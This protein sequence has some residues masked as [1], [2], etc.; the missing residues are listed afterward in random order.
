VRH[1]RSKIHVITTLRKPSAELGKKSFH[2]RRA[3]TGSETN[4]VS[5][6]SVDTGLD[7]VA[8]A[9]KWLEAE[10]AGRPI[11][12]LVIVVG[13]G[14]GYLLEAL[15]NR[16]AETRVLALEPDSTI[17]QAFLARRDWTR[18]REA[19][20]LAYLVDPDY[21]GADE[22]WRMFPAQPD[23]H[24]VLIDPAI[25]RDGGEGALR[26]ARLL[27]RIVFG[28]RANAEARRQFAPRYLTNAIRNVPSLI[29]GSDIRA[30]TDV[31]RG[32]P[33][34]IAAAGPSLDRAL[35][36]LRHVSDRAMLIA[37]DTALRP[38]LDYGLTPALAI[39]MDPSA[40]NGRHFHSLP[41]C[42]ETWL[43]AE[44]ALDPTAAALFGDR[45]F[46][47]RV[48][49]HQPWPWFH[50]LGIDVGQL[51]V[52]GS[53]LTAAFQVAVLAGC[54]PI[55][56][57]GADL[58]Y[59]DGRPYARG[60]TYEFDW[61]YSTGFGDDLEHV[62]RMQMAMLDQLRVPDLCGA[63]TTTTPP[64]EAF[65]DWMVAQAARCGRR[66]VNATGA[67]ILFGKGVEQ[68]SLRT[69]L[70]TRRKISS[71][72]D[73]VR[74]EPAAASRSKLATQF[75][76]VR[77]RIGEPSLAPVADWVEF[78]G[79]GFEAVVTGDA[80]E[81]AARALAT[82]EDGM[83]RHADNATSSRGACLQ[84]SGPILR[85][86]PEG[87]ARL[88][89]ALNAV[90]PLPAVA[91]AANC[92]IADHVVAL[93]HAFELICPLD[94]V[95]RNFDDDSASP[96]AHLGAIRAPVSGVCAWPDEIAWP[97]RRFEALLGMA[98]PTSWPGVEDS[99]FS[100]SVVCRDSDAVAKAAV[101]PGLSNLSREGERLALE[102]LLC[103]SRL[104]EWSA[105]AFGRLRGLLRAFED[106]AES[107]VSCT[108]AGIDLVLGA[109]GDGRSWSVDLP[110]MIDQAALARVLSGMV[111]VPD[112]GSPVLN[113]ATPPTNAAETAL[114]K[115]A[116]VRAP[117]V[118]ARTDITLL[119]IAPRPRSGEPRSLESI[120]LTPRVLTDEGVARSVLGYATT[121]GA[122]FVPI[123]GQASFIVRENGSVEP[124]L[125]WPRAMNGQLPLGVD[126][127]VAWMN[128]WDGP[129]PGYVMYRAGVD[130]TP[131]IQ[132]LPF[133]PTVGAWW[134]NRLYW[135][136]FPSG[137]GSWAPGEAPTVSLPD[138]TLMAIHP[139]ET[140][141]M[142]APCLRD[143][144]GA[145]RRQRST[146]CFRWKPGSPV[147]AVLLGPHGAASCRSSDRGWTAFAYP[148]GDIVSLESD[149]GQ[150]ASMTC[151][152]PFTTA[153]AGRSL[154]VAT[155]QGELLFFEDLVGALQGW[156]Q[157]C[158]A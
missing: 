128:N 150:R 87:I 35:E 137:L 60:T 16:K 7:P 41:D 11:P 40:K 157:S 95:L 115:L 136:S 133:K 154:V 61:A 71:L 69:V 54:D 33:A 152:Y 64:L 2:R 8:E 147:E 120:L 88:R 130:D 26:T 67:G 121:G 9:A 90:E 83:T 124:H 63:Q 129:G 44:T 145:Y 135:T 66:V 125:S 113:A 100:R 89:A 106:G 51:D 25:A 12:P 20:R 3:E 6:G 132:E 73:L 149:D 144:Q 82:S 1:V 84:P 19:G 155:I 146:E 151:Y 62:W 118:T 158:H 98:C 74:R 75:R 138:L 49:D 134:R 139:E 28:A 131:T 55:V 52:W 107:A 65:R 10:L 148:Q 91:S 13:L 45:S 153:W 143:T 109:E 116:H 31:Y 17:A 114:Q 59:T 32:V 56:L 81:A 18:W 117:G 58:A 46:W 36:D 103:A 5:G 48:A 156:F 43:V 105:P 123:V 4:S 141:L 111:T 14:Q 101:A 76:D 119:R 94:A 79:A 24:I 39:G 104:T 34:V 15:E 108:E 57:V 140:G 50:E 42:P 47:F 29:A 86:L 37:V 30:L 127:A 53:V 92:G 68:S 85:Q 97:M 110:V 122:V 22:A 27:K 78:S 21:A 99:F 77:R 142:L 102:W 112:A 80:L 93:D 126:G 70:A 38:L 23:N 72:G 96:L